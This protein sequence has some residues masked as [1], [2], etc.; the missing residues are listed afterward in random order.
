M[1]YIVI[2]YKILVVCP[3]ITEGQQKRFDP[4]TQEAISLAMER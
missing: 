3:S 4:K 2:M 1:E